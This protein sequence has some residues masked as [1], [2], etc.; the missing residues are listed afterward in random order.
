MLVHLLKSLLQRNVIDPLN[1]GARLYFSLLYDGSLSAKTNNE[2]EL[3]LIKTYDKRR[4]A[5]DVHSLLEPTSMHTAGLK[6]SMD[7]AVDKAKLTIP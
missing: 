3:Y 2:K 6:S 1:T 5:F 7:E 4:P